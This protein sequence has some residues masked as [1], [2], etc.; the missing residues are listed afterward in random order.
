[1]P[2]ADTGIPCEVFTNFLVD[3]TPVFEKDIISDIRPS[4]AGMVGFYTNRAWEAYNGSSHTY[5]RFNSVSPDTTKPW[6]SVQ[7]QNCTGRP[8][9]PNENLIGYGSERRTVSLE[10]QSWATDIMCFD[11]VIY[12][13]EAKRHV[14]QIISQVLTPATLRIMAELLQRKAMELAYKR[15][16]VASGLP[17]FNFSWSPGGYIQLNVTNS[18]TGLPIDPT[19]RLTYNILRTQVKEQFAL[20]AIEAAD[21]EFQHL[22]LHTDL[23]T[24][25]YMGKSDPTLYDK[26]RFQFSEFSTAAKEYQ[27]YGLNGY[28]GDFLVKCLMFPPKFNRIAAGQYRVV[29]PYKNVASSTG[30]KSVYN[31]DYDNAQYTF[32][33][34]NHKEAIHVRPFNASA[35][36]PQMPFLVRD[37]A[38]K[39]RFVNDD[40]GCENKRKNKGQFIADFRL[41]LQPMRNE[42]LV[43][44]FH[45]VAPPCVEIIDVCPPDPGNPSQDYNSANASCP[46]TI[47]IRLVTNPEGS[48]QLA[49]NG[50]LCNGNV[51]LTAGIT[52]ATLSG[53]VTALQTAWAAA[54]RT[55]TW[56]VQ[57]ASTNT[58]VLTG[59]TA[60]PLNCQ[61]VTLLMVD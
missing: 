47:A 34:I 7:D 50:G 29:L 42:F 30:I 45:K 33:W 25:Y 21:K 49:A 31:T 19:G 1:M 27:R 12:K 54:G 43:C 51:V 23:D 46:G 18:V 13:T 26:A 59:T 44:F 36:N 57:D 3:Q 48:F 16:V 2:T 24:F 56:T 61:E 38:G 4:A 22:Q 55:G 37:Y 41:A 14:Q 53:F 11:Q 39:W 5:D 17:T 15:I 35:L 58:I 60:T 20:G 6:T 28:I 9:D 10:E 8:C 40:L 52:N 32:S